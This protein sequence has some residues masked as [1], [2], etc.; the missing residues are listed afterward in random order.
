MS[1]RAAVVEADFTFRA[2][3]LVAKRALWELRKAALET[4]LDFD[5]EEVHRGFFD[6]GWIITVKGKRSDVRAYLAS[7]QDWAEKELA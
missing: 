5:A 6:R 7:A 4:G 1:D 2:G 3:R